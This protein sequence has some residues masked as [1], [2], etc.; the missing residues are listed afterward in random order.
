LDFDE[1]PDAVV[2][3]T[4]LDKTENVLVVTTRTV[5]AATVE[6]SV[7]GDA[8]AASKQTAKTRCSGPRNGTGLRHTRH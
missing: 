1:H 3:K 2:F 4:E 7:P 8:D 5:F 6:T